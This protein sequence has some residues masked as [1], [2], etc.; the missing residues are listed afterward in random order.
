MNHLVIWSCFGLFIFYILLTG[1]TT[2]SPCC[3]V[4]GMTPAMFTD[5][6]FWLSI[7]LGCG[8]TLLPVVAWNSYV[9]QFGLDLSN[10]YM[11]GLKPLPMDYQ[12]ATPVRIW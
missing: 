8:V 6:K 12:K 11:P 2:S 4:Y 7:I 5:G 9:N 1:Y 3:D 10:G